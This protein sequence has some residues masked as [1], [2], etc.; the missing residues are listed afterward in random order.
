MND[1]T[2]TNVWLA[3]LAIVSLIEFIIIAAAGFLAF[4]AYKQV[5]SVVENVERMHIAPLRARVDGIL[6]E[7]EVITGKVRHAQ[8]SVGSVLQTAAQAGTAIAGSVKAKTWPVLA[9]I[10]GVR[11]AAS[12]LMN[13]DDKHDQPYITAGT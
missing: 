12:S 5:M 10:R 13:K 4:R 2:M 9:V 7:V 8:D 1:L 3:I 11:T 6:D